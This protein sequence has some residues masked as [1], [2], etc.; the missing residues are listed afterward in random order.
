MIDSL[1]Y[2]RSNFIDRLFPCFLFG[3]LGLGLLIDSLKESAYASDS[4]IDGINQEC[5]S[6]LSG[7]KSEGISASNVAI[8]RSKKLVE[9]GRLVGIAPEVCPPFSRDELSS[10]IEGD[11]C[12]E[13]KWHVL[14]SIREATPGSTNVG[15]RP[16]CRI[17]PN[18]TL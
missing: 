17:Q 18:L 1:S 6:Q 5:Q 11:Q 3:S 13:D 4:K 12:A 9:I 15:S 2:F 10:K 8:D 14:N 7:I 16:F